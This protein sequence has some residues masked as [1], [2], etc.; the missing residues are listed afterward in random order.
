[1][2]TGKILAGSVNRIISSIIKYFINGDEL[3][4]FVRIT[5]QRFG[6]TSSQFIE[7]Q[8]RLKPYQ[9]ALKY[10]ANF[11]F[12]FSRPKYSYL[13]FMRTKFDIPSAQLQ[14]SWI[15]FTLRTCPRS[16]LCAWCVC[17]S[18]NSRW[19]A[20]LFMLSNQRKCWWWGFKS[21]LS[22]ISD[23]YG[24][25]IRTYYGVYRHRRAWIKK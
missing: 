11:V 6:S 19:N 21:I 3:C 24:N 1:M 8:F 23:T 16:M 7:D 20:T 18:G 15:Q 25:L 4:F 14:S 22:G 2:I 9:P 5:K 10:F 13:Q 12:I 17:C